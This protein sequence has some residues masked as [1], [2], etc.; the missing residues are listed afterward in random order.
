[1][2]AVKYRWADKGVCKKGDVR[3]FGCGLVVAEAL[4]VAPS[5]LAGN[6]FENSVQ[7]HCSGFMVAVEMDG[8]LGASWAEPKK[9]F[10]YHYTSPSG[11]LVRMENL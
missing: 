1:M 7:E 6:I 8:A 5:K 3:F 11:T 4:P 9:S 10:F 2:V